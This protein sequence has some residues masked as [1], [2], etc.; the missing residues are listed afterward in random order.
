MTSF[1]QQ[2]LGDPPWHSCKECMQLSSIMHCSSSYR[3]TATLHVLQPEE[4]PAVKKTGRK[5]LR[6]TDKCAL[7]F[8]TSHIMLAAG[9]ADNY[10]AFVALLTL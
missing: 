3:L 9:E 2:H 8:Q 7:P 1:W 6:R 10:R 4:V 5:Q